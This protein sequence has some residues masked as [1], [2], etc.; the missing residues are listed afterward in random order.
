MFPEKYC[1]EG[2]TIV[3]CSHCGITHTVSFSGVNPLTIE[4]A[5]EEA[6]EADGWGVASMMCPECFDSMEEQ[7]ERDALIEES[8]DFDNIDDYE[9]YYEYEEED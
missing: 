5:I 6:M 9:D 8:A 4:Q 3:K 2:E 1:F 7:R